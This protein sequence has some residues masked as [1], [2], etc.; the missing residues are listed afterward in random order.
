LKDFDHGICCPFQARPTKSYIMTMFNDVLFTQE[1]KAGSIAAHLTSSPRHVISHAGFGATLGV[2]DCFDSAS[3]HC[4]LTYVT[5]IVDMVR[6]DGRSLQLEGRKLSFQ[7]WASLLLSAWNGEFGVCGRVHSHTV[8]ASRRPVH[9]H[10][11]NPKQHAEAIAQS[12]VN[13]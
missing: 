9:H 8:N 5:A 1:T 10:N 7:S 3:P 12:F 2:F 4:Y 13:T 6:L 11:M